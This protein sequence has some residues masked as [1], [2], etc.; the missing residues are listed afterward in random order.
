[1][2]VSTIIWIFLLSSGYITQAQ[3]LT[4]SLEKTIAMAT[5]SLL[6]AFRQRNLYLASYWQ[7]RTYKAER[8]PSLSLNVTP[9]QYYRYITQRYN[10]DENIDVYRTQQNYLASGGLSV[11]QNFDVLGGSFYINSDLEYLR[12]FGDNNYHQYTSVPFR[13][14]YYQDLLGYNPYK[15]QKKIEPVKFEKAK[16]ELI[17][18][19]EQI[20]EAATNYFFTLAMAQVEYDMA[21]ENMASSDTLYRIGQER[22]KIA[23]ITQADLLTLKLDAVNARNT[24]KNK[25]IEL[26]RAMF[27]L[28]SYL[29]FDKN[30]DI[31]LD[32]P[33][34]PRNMEIFVDAALIYARE[35]HPSYL[36][37]QQEILEAERDVDKTRKESMF[38]ATFQASVGFNQVS[39]KLREAYMDLLRQDIVSVS[40][41]IPL[42]DWGV[43]RGK[44]NMAKNNLAIARISARQ[45]ELSIEE[46]VIMTVSDFNIQQDLIISA[47]EAL[48]LAVMAYAETRQ[49]FI[50]GKE[51]INSLTLSLQRQQEA[52]RNYISSLQNYWLSYYKI[53]RLTLHDFDTGFSL[54]TLF[55]YKNGL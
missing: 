31:R 27:S 34:R 29:S 39:G 2:R 20:S 32:L 42:V 4:L 43:R 15:W 38:N 1:M 55:D 11:N 37:M 50:I 12:N 28:A 5:D 41:S 44:Y 6:D 54:S 19:M 23:S 48:E 14:G 10:Y 51:D 18:N 36:G 24:L 47:E 52:Q 53:R 17:Y 21:V 35:N 13:V 7:Y 25:E 8:L 26:K 3:K 33:G 30:T 40:V 49:R 45:E 9:A 46:D 22:Q 16:K